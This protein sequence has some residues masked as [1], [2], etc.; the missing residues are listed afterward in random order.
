[1]PFVDP[2]SHQSMLRHALKTGIA[3]VLAYGIAHLFHLKYGYWATLSA[4]IVMQVYVADSVQMCLYRFSG[5]AVGALI[6]MIAILLFPATPVMTVVALFLSVGFCAY[7]TRYNARYRMAAITVCIVV[8]ASIDQ[9]NRLVFG[10]LRVVEIGLGVA[11]AFLVSVLLWPVRAGTALKARLMERF[12]DCARHYE[13][14]MDAFLAMQSGLDPHL[15]DQ[16]QK[17]IRDDRELFQK[18]LRHERRMYHEDTDLLGLKVRTLE[19]CQSH[20]QTMLQA[21]NS[22]QGQG[23]EIIMDRE[24]R[25]LASVTVEGMREIVSG[26]TPSTDLLTKALDASEARL[27]ELRMGGA[28]RRFHLQKLVQFFTFYHSAQSMGRDIL[29]YSR[30]P[31]FSAQPA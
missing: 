7:M 31:L 1:M 3:A 20:L 30:N 13:T 2:D 22:E 28:T 4:V 16:F 5:T 18:V 15:L 26:R 12:G 6:G 14:I 29:L 10:M 11:A 8:L 24:L 21:L 23:Y 25:E 27:H 19:K 9:E 17:D